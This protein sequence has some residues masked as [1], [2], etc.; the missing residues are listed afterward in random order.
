MRF[1]LFGIAQVPCGEQFIVS[2]FNTL[3]LNMAKMIKRA[4][5]HLTFYG[6]S[7]STAPRDEFVEVV[8][9]E[10][11]A[12][13]YPTGLVD[14]KETPLMECQ[15]G[16]HPWGEFLSR[17]ENALQER[18]RTG[19]IGLISY[20]HTQ[21]RLADLCALHVEFCCGYTGIFSQNRVFP[22]RAW[23]HNLYGQLGAKWGGG[24]FDA[25]IP[26]MMDADLFP[27]SFEP[28]KYLLH[29]GRL[30]MDKGTDIAV[31]VAR[32][33]H[34]PIIVAG[35]ADEGNF[36][37]DFL[38]GM[39]GLPGVQFTGRVSPEQRLRLL[40]GAIALLS[41]CRYL[42]AFALTNIEALACGTPVI[43]P[44]YG[45]FPEVIEDGKTGFICHDMADFL[46]AV[47]EAP[48][49]SREA[50][51]QSFM[52]R[53]SL[54][55][56]WPQY[57][58]YFRRLT[59]QLDE[60]WY[61]LEDGWRGTSIDALLRDLGDV[62]NQTIVEVGVGDGKLSEHLLEEHPS[63]RLI[64]VDNWR[65]A[66]AD[67][68][69]RRSGDV[70][71]L[72]SLREV[73]ADRAMAVERTKFANGRHVIVNGDSVVAAEK[74]AGSAHLVFLDAD[75]TFKALC[76]DI[77]AWWPK[78]K[79]GGFLAGHDFGNDAQKGCAGVKD[80]VLRFSQ[81]VGLPI[82]REAGFVWAIQKPVEATT[83]ERISPPEDQLCTSASTRN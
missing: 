72:R 81:K 9:A 74:L 2:P 27:P 58:R 29:L 66:P 49:L 38:R 47:K 63:A 44:D 77:E 15:G 40:R 10:A 1:H 54:D 80:A 36:L 76:A 25:V 70:A 21:K 33:A 23:Q 60:Q 73:L 50:C 5:H 6:P 83:L 18:Y 52:D 8:S 34:I 41:P 48:S 17:A 46:R 65:V 37:P 55:A 7:G 78:V 68:E 26:H 12:A 35:S 62:G 3:A 42:E 16:P 64:M 71:A 14:P 59:K 13:C 20:G 82:R 11:V 61:G 4:G 53:F 69:Y 22:S 39:K 79:P 75:H 56:V 43:G 30:N 31:D 67:S 24:W 28:G 45:A 32:R 51:R 19:D 57:E